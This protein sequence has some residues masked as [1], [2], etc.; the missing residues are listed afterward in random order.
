MKN[1]AS[2]D[3]KINQQFSRASFARPRY[4]I[5]SQSEIS[6]LVRCLNCEWSVTADSEQSEP[7]KLEKV[8]SIH[9]RDAAMAH[10]KN[11]KSKM[12]KFGY[13]GLLLVALL[14]TAVTLAISADDRKIETIDATATGTSTQLGKT[15]NVL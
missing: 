3:G 8:P 6:C 7:S 2:F 11:S 10:S 15:V 5:G 1:V 14:L 12:H 9:R 13:G 4:W